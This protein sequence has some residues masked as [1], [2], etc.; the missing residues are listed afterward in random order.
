LQKCWARNITD[1]YLNQT[2]ANCALV[3]VSDDT[4]QV[5]QLPPWLGWTLPAKQ[6]VNKPGK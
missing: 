5:S 3:F 4:Y 6:S 2:E 1:T